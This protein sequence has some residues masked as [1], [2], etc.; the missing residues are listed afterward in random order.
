MELTSNPRASI[1]P[2][3]GVDACTE[4]LRRFG[5]AP[6]LLNVAQPGT[7]ASNPSFPKLRMAAQ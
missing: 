5:S 6:L 7:E 2:G 3:P 1:G 4:R